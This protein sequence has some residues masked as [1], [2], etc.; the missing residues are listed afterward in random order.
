MTSAP[1]FPPRAFIEFDYKFDSDP[2]MRAHSEQLD[3]TVE[4]LSTIEHEALTAE[5]QENIEKA[6]CLVLEAVAILM[7]QYGT[8]ATDRG[9]RRG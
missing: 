7:R 2:Y 9:D 5:L 1:N 3:E 6:E 4:Y 8:K